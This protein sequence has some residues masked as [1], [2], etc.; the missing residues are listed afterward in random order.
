MRGLLWIIIGGLQ[1]IAE[2]TL[3]HCLKDRGRW[4]GALVALLGVL[5]VC[6]LLF[7]IACQS[8]GWAISNRIASDGVALTARR[9]LITPLVSSA[10][11]WL[12]GAVVITVCDG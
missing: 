8:A 4:R 1:I 11:N 3:F 5:P 12:L 9:I 7:G 2:P 10:V 6:H